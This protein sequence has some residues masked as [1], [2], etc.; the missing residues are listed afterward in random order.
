ME[1]SRRTLGK[2]IASLGAALA[3]RPAVA[4]GEAS[5][6]YDVHL[7]SDTMVGMRDRVR[8][9]T[10]IYRPA[11]SGKPVKGKFPVI[12][13]RTPYNRQN[14]FQG[15]FYARRGFAEFLREPHAGGGEIVHMRKSVGVQDS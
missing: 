3:A 11:R 2:L 15:T 4:A 7:T 12:L 8:L 9:A 5:G 10:D 1:F 13:E 6:E 14:S